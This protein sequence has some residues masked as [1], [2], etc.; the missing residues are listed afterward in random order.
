MGII[1]LEQNLELEN[2]K[3]SGYTK[4]LRSYLDGMNFSEKKTGKKSTD[5]RPPSVLKISNHYDGASEA[6]RA[7][8]SHFGTK[9]F[10][11]LPVFY[12]LTANII[13]NSSEASV[14]GTYNLITH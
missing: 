10:E 2:G 5:H 3:L 8:V 13:Q 4:F 14:K 6:L 9:L 11:S 1:S 12:D 7:I